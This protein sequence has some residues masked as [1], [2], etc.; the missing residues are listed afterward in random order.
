MK[1]FVAALP[2]VTAVIASVVTWLLTE[3][4]HRKHVR[5]DAK[6]NVDTLRRAEQVKALVDLQQL[7]LEY[8]ETFSEH[9]WSA[10]ELSERTLKARALQTKADESW[11]KLERLALRL[12]AL[13]ARIDDLKIR[14]LVDHVEE[15]ARWSTVSPGEHIEGPGKTSRSS[16][17]VL[18]DD[19]R[20]QREAISL[21]LVIGD[22]LL[23]LLG[24][25]NPELAITRQS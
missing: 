19:Q 8:Y 9:L 17:N 11:E 16:K 3:H 20:V 10:W 2:L 14:S 22:R 5:E 6:G 1:V 7:V 25:Q 4:S 15:I 13:S 21:N 23:E 12:F 24:T 18:D